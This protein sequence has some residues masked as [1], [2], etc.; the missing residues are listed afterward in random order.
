MSIWILIIVLI[1][2]G[3]VL[4]CLI[5]VRNK[6]KINLE[7]A[8]E[9]DPYTMPFVIDNFISDAERKYIIEQSVDKLVDSKI[10][11]GKNNLVRNSQQNWLPKTDTVIREIFDRASRTFNLPIENAEDL[12][13]VRYKPGQYYNEH[14][15]SCCDNNKHCQSFIKKGGQRILTILIYLNDDFEDGQTYFKNLNQKFKVKP[16]GAIVFY[17]L[18]SDSNKCHPKALHAGLPVSSGEKWIANLWF[19]E[20]KFIK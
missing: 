19:R 8:I 17:P 18:A 12:Q 10:V 14:H 16:G 7:F 15:D 1:I 6:K 11:S 9:T 5:C 3:V 2:I 13:V 4:I 20:R